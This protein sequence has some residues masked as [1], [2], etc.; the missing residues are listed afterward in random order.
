MFKKITLFLLL[1]I[2]CQVSCHGN[3]KLPYS[4]HDIEMLGKLTIL[5]K[6]KA[7]ILIKWYW[8]FFYLSN[9]SNRSLVFI[10]L[11]VFKIVTDDKTIGTTSKNT[12]CISTEL[13]PNDE[14]SSWP[15]IETE[16]DKV[17]VSFWYTNATLIP[18]DQTIPGISNIYPNCSEKSP[19]FLHIKWNGRIGVFSEPFD[20][21]KKVST[22]L[23][24]KWTMA[25]N[26]F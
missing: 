15:T 26:I 12:G 1:K 19:I 22:F 17:C 25:N 6:N 7:I 18:G 13:P 14:P 8:K 20:Q 3:L 9:S 11:F 4:W 2:I 24:Q 5:V 16:K 10:A 21:I 23:M